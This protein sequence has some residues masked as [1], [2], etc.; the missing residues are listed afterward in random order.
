MVPE[1]WLISVSQTVRMGRAIRTADWYSTRGPK[2]C[3]SPRPTGVL[4]NA[5]VLKPGVAPTPSSAEAYNLFN[6][7]NFAVP[8]NTQSSLTLGEMGT[9]FSRMQPG[10]SPIMPD[11]YSAQSARGARFN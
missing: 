3:P 11:E 2:R 1:A 6:H 10:I 9:P 4:F 7:P 5:A 8:S